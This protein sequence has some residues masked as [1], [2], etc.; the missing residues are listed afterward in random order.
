[1][2]LISMISISLLGSS[3]L[4]LDFSMK[5]P[6]KRIPHGT[7]RYGFSPHEFGLEF[8]MGSSSKYTVRPIDPSG[9]VLVWEVVVVV[10]VVINHQAKWLVAVMFNRSQE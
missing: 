7:K 9:K 2:A 10:L 1:M 3:A 8:F 4:D 5:V 6:L